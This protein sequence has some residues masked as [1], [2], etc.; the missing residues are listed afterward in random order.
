MVYVLEF[1]ALFDLFLYY[2][3]TLHCIQCLNGIEYTEC[4][5]YNTDYPIVAFTIPSTTPYIGFSSVIAFVPFY[6]S[7]SSYFVEIFCEI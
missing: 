6:L 3:V 5:K 7:I 2:P 4:N 1:L